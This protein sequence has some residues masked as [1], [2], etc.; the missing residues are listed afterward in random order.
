MGL[1]NVLKRL[2]LECFRW[3]FRVPCLAVAL[4]V[5][6][7]RLAGRVLQRMLGSLLFGIVSESERILI[8]GAPN[9]GKSAL[10][11]RIKLG[12]FIQTVATSC[13]IEEDTTLCHI[14][15][16]PSELCMH[17]EV[18]HFDAIHVCLCEC[19]INDDNDVVEDQ[20]KYSSRVLLVLDST[21]PAA[22]GS[23][24]QHIANVI[25]QHNFFHQSPK[26]VLF[27]NKTDI[28]GS[29]TASLMPQLNKPRHLQNRIIW[30]NGSAL[31]GEGIVDALK[32]L[33][34]DEQWKIRTSSVHEIDDLIQFN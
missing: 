25:T 24:L 17:C 9:S 18:N 26:Y 29:N 11:Y 1:F 3:A 6:T 20:I 19:G 33:L 5:R 15:I 4:V 30:V 27:N 31:T 34:L 16:A 7:V 12:E 23:A 21:D 8:I 14:C 10:L 2:P 22:T 13:Y 28:V 32:F